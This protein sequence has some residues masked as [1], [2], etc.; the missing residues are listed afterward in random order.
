MA[1]AT[2]HGVF[3]S[4]KIEYLNTVAEEL[5]EEM[6]GDV[7]LRNVMEEDTLSKGTIKTMSRDKC[8]KATCS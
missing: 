8:H 4:S 3:L 2:L 1:I 6:P 7:T 5:D